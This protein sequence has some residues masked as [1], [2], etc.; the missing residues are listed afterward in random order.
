MLAQALALMFAASAPPDPAAGPVPPATV[1]PLEVLKPPGK[2]PPP[3]AKLDMPTS[4]DDADTRFVFWPATAYQARYDGRVTLRCLIDTHGLAEHCD[5]ASESPTGHGFGRAAL[6]MRPTLKLTP[7]QGPDGP[8][9]RVVNVAVQFT[10][11]EFQHIGGM[12]L[13]RPLPMTAVTLLDFPQWSAAPTFDDLAAAYPAKADGGDGYVVL[14]CVVLHSGE[15]HRCGVIKEDPEQR[16]FGAAALSLS[17]KFRVAA[18]LTKPPQHSE[19][20]VNIPIRFP[21]RQELA[22][23]AVTAPTWVDSFDARHVPKLF[24]PEAVASGV[25]S[26]RGVARCVVGPDGALTDCRPEPG[27]PDGLGFS[28]A[29]VKLASAMKMNLWSADAE[30]VEGGVIDIPIRLNLKPDAD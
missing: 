11:P 1:S 10:A 19:L 18:S 24:P 16:E 25:T 22:R 30:P 20:W 29:A 5:V 17:S 15:V 2:P 13:G 12:M 14:R 27:S 6:E 9:S 26:G 28:E 8:V 3:D 7:P 4:S 23:R 21:T